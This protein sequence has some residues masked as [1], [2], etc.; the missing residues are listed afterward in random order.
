MKKLT[1]LSK[2]INKAEIILF[3][4][5]SKKELLL[6]FGCF[7][8]MVV[9]MVAFLSRC[10][11]NTQSQTNS[12]KSKLMN[13]PTIESEKTKSDKFF[14]IQGV[15]LFPDYINNDLTADYQDLY[16]LNNYNRENLGL[17]LNEFDTVIEKSLAE[18]LSF[19][20]EK[21]SKK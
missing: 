13:S 6:F 14:M 21:R 19:N 16:P 12:L 5:N 4:T 10:D 7:F 3:F 8:I 20:F 15:L 2:S 18:T 11:G 9:I 1:D 17:I